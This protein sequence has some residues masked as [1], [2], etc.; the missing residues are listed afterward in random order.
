MALGVAAVDSAAFLAS[1]KR[2]VAFYSRWA[3]QRDVGTAMNVWKANVEAAF[4][5]AW[6]QQF[7]ADASRRPPP[8]PTAH[9]VSPQRTL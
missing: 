4:R 2:V 5:E 8:A 3:R 7:L 6:R 9:L 1:A